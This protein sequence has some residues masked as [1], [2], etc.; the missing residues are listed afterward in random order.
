MTGS[1]LLGSPPNNKDDALIRKGLLRLSPS[2][3][4]PL[5]GLPF[6]PPRPAGAVYESWAESVQIGLAFSIFLVIFF[7][8]AR[9]S[10]R[11]FYTHSLGL[12][13]LFIVPAALGC[14]VYLTLTILQ[15]APGCLG[16]H[17]WDCTYSGI[18]NYYKWAQ[19]VFP[20]F[21]FTVFSAKL[22]IAL[23]NRRMT[24]MVSWGWQYVHWTFIIMFAILL[25]LLTL[26]EAF[27]CH[28]VEVSYS[29]QFI[30][31]LADPKTVGCPID[32]PAFQYAPRAIHAATDVALLSVPIV[33]LFQLQAPW[34][35]KARLIAIFALG[36][37]STIASIIRNVDLGFDGDDLPWKVRPVVILNIVDV[38]TALVVANLPA[39]N[40]TV[41]LAYDKMKSLSSVFTSSG[42]HHSGRSKHSHESDGTTRGTDDKHDG[43][44]KD[45]AVYSYVSNTHASDEQVSVAFRA[46]VRSSC[47][48]TSTNCTA[49]ASSSGGHGRKK[50]LSQR[51]VRQFCCCSVDYETTMSYCQTRKLISHMESRGVF[52]DARCCVCRLDLVSSG[53]HNSRSRLPD[54]PQTL[55]DPGIERIQWCSLPM[56]THPPLRCASNQLQKKDWPWYYAELA[57]RLQPAGR[58]VFEEEC[59]IPPAERDQAWEIFPFP[60]VGQFWFIEFGLSRHPRY[61]E[62][63]QLLKQASAQ[64][65]VPTDVQQ[66]DGEPLPVVE[67]IVGSPARTRLLDVGTCV[68]QD[69][70]MLRHHGVSNAAL[71]GT[72]LMPGF[73]DVGHNLF[74]DKETFQNHY[75]VAD[76]FDASSASPLVKTA[77]LWDVITANMFIHQFD[78]K[79]QQLAARR[80][81]SLLRDAKGSIIL[82]SITGQLDAGP[83]PLKP[84][85]TDKD[86]TRMTYR[87]SKETMHKLWEDAVV[88]CGGGVDKWHIE[89]TYDEAAL[90]VRKQE[91]NTQGEVHYFVGDTQRRIQYYLRRL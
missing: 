78:L 41:D 22:S 79:H 45:T 62:I 40:V 34:R 77:G 85:F 20:I 19:T 44:R 70:R 54:T 76:L 32:T 8:V 18:A 89:C 63:V 43:I 82:G 65:P 31:A 83:E 16:T 67:E 2:E 74:L 71:Y 13:D 6:G 11:R 72:D 75:I 10:V 26:L 42:T 28:P 59:G 51:L 60:C 46:T 15:S 9:L 80:M 52:Y 30:G 68:G 21:Y 3:L 88:E 57:H 91:R 56:A 17:I 86:R 24:M 27:R 23:Q 12:D 1:A 35:K 64:Q 90:V 7:T 84:P 36:G 48:S 58:K 14:V 4:N 47:N 49:F 37:L 69:L 5:P 53:P 61:D 55:R 81:V 29:L 33:I 73:E 66:G 38:T 50:A 39:L 25:P 87:N